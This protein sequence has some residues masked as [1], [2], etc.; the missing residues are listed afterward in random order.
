VPQPIPVV[1]ALEWLEV[2]VLFVAP[3]DHFIAP[4]W[5]L[6][7]GPLLCKYCP[8]LSNPARARAAPAVFVLR[9]DT[10][11]G[12]TLTASVQC[13]SGRGSSH[14]PPRHEVAL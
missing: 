4:C 8:N 9:V 6:H 14:R 10:R 3:L 12:D 7:P 2:L 1:A 11:A 13:G 5:G